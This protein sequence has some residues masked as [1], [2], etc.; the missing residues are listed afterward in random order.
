[1]QPI[2]VAI[3]D[4]DAGRR[5]KLERALQSEQGVRVLTNVATSGSGVT[6]NRRRQS[7][8]GMTAVEDAVARVRR[9]NPRILLVNLNQGTSADGEMLLSLGRECPETMIILMADESQPQEEQIVQA[10]SKGA[11]GILDFDADPIL[12]TKAVQVID[13]G[14]AWVPRRMLGRLMDQVWHWHH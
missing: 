13:R 5:A 6:R 11:R 8:Q 12:I 7:R 14:E 4:E 3:A 9:L 1:M 2:T 10:L